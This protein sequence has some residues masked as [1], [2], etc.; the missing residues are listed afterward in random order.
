MSQ[1]THVVRDPNAPNYHQVREATEAGPYGVKKFNQSGKIFPPKEYAGSNVKG[2]LF[3]HP[4]RHVTME[5]GM[6][7]TCPDCNVT[8][9]G[10]DHFKYGCP[11]WEA[12]VR[13]GKGFAYC[14]GA[15]LYHGQ[16]H[17]NNEAINAMAA[18]GVTFERVNNQHPDWLPHEP[19]FDKD[20]LTGRWR[21]TG[22]VPIDV[23]ENLPANFRLEPMHQ[24]NSLESRIEMSNDL[25]HRN[26]VTLNS[27]RHAHGRF[28]DYLHAHWY[29]AQCELKDRIL[30]RYEALVFEY[31]QQK[32]HIERLESQIAV[33]K[34]VVN[35]SMVLGQIT[36][37]AF[38]LYNL[39]FDPIGHPRYIAPAT[40]MKL[41]SAPV[42][43]G[44]NSIAKT[45][46]D[47]DLDDLEDMDDY[48]PQ[49]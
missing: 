10:L 35:A 19:L 14:K 18:R 13:L 12:R 32:A 43:S 24:N 11:R 47:L 7:F 2:P 29:N 6:E 48:D 25:G 40:G 20:P 15:G 4:V 34:H 26:M 39:C 27:P 1:L 16:Q 37:G 23:W 3:Y 8:Y 38:N 5:V 44:P 30:P 28:E 31:E 49:L 9:S 33:G 46:S 22:I 42:P 17:L 41:P 45:N 36:P 21:S